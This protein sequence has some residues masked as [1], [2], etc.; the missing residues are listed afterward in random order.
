MHGS[1]LPTILYGACR[2][3]TWVLRLGEGFELVLPDQKG[4]GGGDFRTYH[5]SLSYR[6]FYNFSVIVSLIYQTFSYNYYFSKNNVN[7]FAELHIFWPD[8]RVVK[9]ARQNCNITTCGGGGGVKHF[10]IPWTGGAFAPRGPFL[11]P[12]T[13]EKKWP[14]APKPGP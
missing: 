1:R 6:N 9:I 4:Q 5:F 8:E 13:E 7:I 12:I 3:V 11:C 10:L 2:T 14:I